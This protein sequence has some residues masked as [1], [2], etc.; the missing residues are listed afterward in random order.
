[1][2]RPPASALARPGA[3]AL[4]VLRAFRRNQGVMLAGAVAYYTLLSIVP[5][6]ILLV[7]G[8]SRAV[9]QD[10][11]LATIG[12][13]L[14]LVLPSAGDAVVSALD[15][16]LDTGVVMSGILLVTLVVFSSLAFTALENAFAVIFHHR[17]PVRHRHWFVSA[18]IPY[19]FIA[20]LGVGLLVVTLVAG[21]LQALATREIEWFGRPVTVDA[22][23]SAILYAIGFA[24]EVLLLASIYFFMPVGRISW[25]RALTG[26]L[27]A[28]AL[29][30]LTRH[31]LVWYFASLSQVRLVYGA[32]ATTI[33]ILLSLEIAAIVLLLG[34]QVIAE[35]ER[36]LADV[37]PPAP[38]ATG[39][40]A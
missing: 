8:L 37:G 5:L 40:E 36:R 12:R 38:P 22:M 4:D 19:C 13:Y 34:A 6:L 3:F 32:F 1:M 39:P 14:D 7:F 28:G 23:S 21:A 10:E 24:G 27:V 25:R 2:T 15:A 17:L 35:F 11:L 31:A 29:W 30:E 18:V 20:V 33:A 9:P 16:F 26:G